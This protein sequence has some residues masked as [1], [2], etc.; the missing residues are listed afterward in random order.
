[1]CSFPRIERLPDDFDE[2]LALRTLELV[3]NPVVAK[4]LLGLRF[5]L[6]SDIR[7]HGNG[8]VQFWITI[9]DL[10]DFPHLRGDCLGRIGS[11][12]SSASS[13]QHGWGCTS[14]SPWAPCENVIWSMMNLSRRM[15]RHWQWACL[16]GELPSVE[17]TFDK[18]DMFKAFSQ[19]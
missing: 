15:G 9:A 1:M 3:G 16:K 11:L 18:F 12:G 2:F 5:A 13:T 14:C 10:H 6:T 17:A 4:M 8:S 7:R 19:I